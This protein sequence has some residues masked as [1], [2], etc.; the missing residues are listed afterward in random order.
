MPH[1]QYQVYVVELSKKVFTENTKFW[2]AN[3][4]FNGVLEGLVSLRPLTTFSFLEH[5]GERG[6][7]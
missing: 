6:V 7:I 4:K 1:V 5:L 3:L 2:A